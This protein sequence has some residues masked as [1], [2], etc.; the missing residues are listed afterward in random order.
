MLLYKAVNCVF[1]TAVL[2]EQLMLTTVSCVAD[3]SVSTVCVDVSKMFFD[4]N[5]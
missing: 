1:S 5:L 2:Q 4:L 3:E